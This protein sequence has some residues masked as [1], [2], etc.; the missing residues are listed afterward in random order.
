MP[1]GM[2]CASSQLPFIA[3]AA[4]FYVLAELLYVAPE[5]PVVVGGRSGH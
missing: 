4:T 5:E 1:A 2:T 3:V